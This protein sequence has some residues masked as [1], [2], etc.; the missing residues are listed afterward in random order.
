VVD[1]AND[2][3]NLASTMNQSAFNLGNSIGAWAGGAAITSGLNYVDL[4]WIGASIGGAGLALTL[5]FA[6]HRQ[7]APA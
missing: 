2:A 1:A 3:P 4:P 7:H 6:I 5:F